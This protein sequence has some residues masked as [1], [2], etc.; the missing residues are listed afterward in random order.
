MPQCIAQQDQSI[1]LSTMTKCT[2]KRCTSHFGMICTHG[3][4]LTQ[5]SCLST[6]FSPDVIASYL[7]YC[8]RSIL[9]KAQLYSW[10]RNLT[11][12]T[13]LVEVGDANGLQELTPTSLAK[14]YAPVGVIANA[15]KCLIDST[16]S[17]SMDPFQYVIASCGFTSTSQDTGNSARPWEYRESLHSM[18]ALDFETVGYDIVGDRIRDGDYFDK[19]CFC[20]VFTIN[21]AKEPCS[22]SGQLEF[23]KE[24]LWM[25]ATCGSK[26]LPNNWTETLMTTQ[27]SFIAIEDWRWPVCVADMPK[28]V[29]ALTDQCATDAC[30]L[31]SSGYCN[32]KRA[33]DRTCFC[34]N[35][36]YDSCTGSCH[37]FETRIDYIKWL[38]GLCEN[39][40]DWHGLPDSWHRLAA[41]IPFD[42]IP[43]GWTIRRFVDLTITNITSLAYAKET[44]MCPLNQWKL[45]SF[46]TVNIATFLATFLSLGLRLYPF[47]S[48][49]QNPSHP[50]SWILKGTIVVALQ[51]LANLL[52]I[53]I[54][55][56]TPGYSLDASLVLSAS[57]YMANDSPY[58]FTAI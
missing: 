15:P 28:R 10:I 46:A 49:P 33:V 7:P 25:N 23:T 34:R 39:V 21:L 42:L 29:I 43:W 20:H 50:W 13:W 6:T 14:G 1:W 44:E 36:S 38:R 12:R 2:N 41:P 24:R 9:A 51:L 48:H 3:Q 35:I 32:V 45:G 26:F 53:F 30:E 16:S 57:P 22:G 27:F 5:L 54:A 40:Q 17:L 8:D 55:Q 11:G 56:S 18:I 19:D 47:T 58:W 52:N 31:D 4:W 37:I